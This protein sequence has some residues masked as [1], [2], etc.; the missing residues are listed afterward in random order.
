MITID[1]RPAKRRFG[2]RKQWRF[3]IRAGNRE[4]I[5]PRDTYANTRDITDVVR[6]LVASDEPVQVV[7]H[8]RGGIITERIR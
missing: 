7:T 3:T 4:L 8:N 1:I 2:G 6:K 5:D